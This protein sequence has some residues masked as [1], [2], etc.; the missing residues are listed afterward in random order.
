VTDG[1]QSHPR[2]R[3]YPAPVLQQVRQEETC[4]A[5]SRLGSIA[6]TFLQ[7]PDG[8]L[9]TVAA[10]QSNQNIC[11]DYLEA[12]SPKIIFLP[13]RHDPHPDHR[14]TWR[15][16]TNAIVDARVIV[17][18]IEYPIWGWDVQQL[19]HLPNPD[20]MQAWRLDIQAVLGAKRQ[21]IAAYRSQI[22]NLID[23]DPE[24]FRLTPA[25]LA[26]FTQPWEV[27]FEEIT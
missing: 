14:A 10:L 5:L 2:S 27:Y 17:R 21:A 18:S 7:L 23:D 22:T 1:T 16:L 19:H 4:L 15:L 3:Q 8:K 20:Q 12:R 26:H 9:S 13:W 25:M 24:G 11:R 6:V